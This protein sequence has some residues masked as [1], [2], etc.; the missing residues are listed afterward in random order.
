M[1]LIKPQLRCTEAGLLIFESPDFVPAQG[2]HSREKWIDLATEFLP[3][4]TD[5]HDGITTVTVD[6][7]DDEF[8]EDVAVRPGI[9]FEIDFLTRLT[10]ILMTHETPPDVDPVVKLKSFDEQ[11]V[12]GGVYLQMQKFLCSGGVTMD[13]ARSVI[14]V[15]SLSRGREIN[16]ESLDK[17]EATENYFRGGWFRLRVDEQKFSVT[18][19]RDGSKTLKWPTINL[20]TLGQSTTYGYISRPKI[21]LNPDIMSGIAELYTQTFS[22]ID[23]NLDALSLALGIARLA[24]EA[25]NYK[26]DIDITS[27][28]FSA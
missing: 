18:D 24:D 8:Q 27:E 7:R 21:Y 19:D 17:F 3:V 12:I 23:D 28:Q 1:T 2:P 16:A 13:V 6:L 11:S 26:G 9:P 14:D 22:N 10:G 5:N 25:M 4:T 20:E 15:M